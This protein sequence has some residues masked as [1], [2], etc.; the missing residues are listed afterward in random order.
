MTSP[1]SNASVRGEN[2]NQAIANCYTLSFVDQGQGTL[3]HELGIRGSDLNMN[4][5]TRIRCSYGLA[6]TPDGASA[7]S[8]SLR[9]SQLDIV[10]ERCV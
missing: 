9:L 4:L 6:G 7:P 10:R 5:R 1:N 3:V 2:G 8:A